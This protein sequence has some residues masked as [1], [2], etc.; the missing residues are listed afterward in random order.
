MAAWEAAL[1]TL[2]GLY[3]A[4]DLLFRWMG[5][6]ALAHGPRT[7]ARLALTFDDGPNP[8]TTPELLGILEDLKLHAT[9]FLTGRRA[10][11][12]PE[13][14]EAIR[15]AGHELASHGL[16]H[17]PAFLMAP[18]T[19][20]VHTGYDPGGLPLYRPPHGAHSPFTRLF[21]RMLGKQVALWDLESKDWT[22]MH[23]EALLERL[24]ELAQPGSVVL[25]HDG[26]PRTPGL[27]RR[28]VP[29]LQAMGYELVPLSAMELRPLSFK[30]GLIRA[31]Q[32]FDERYDRAHGIRRCRRSADNLFRC[33]PAPFPVDL[34]ELPK[35]TP[36]LELHFD[37]RRVAAKSPL[38]IVKA[39]RRDLTHAAERVKA[40][41]RIQVV[42]A[43]TPL[44]EGARELLGFELFDLP[45]GRALVDALSRRFFDWLYRDPRY[46]PKP[47]YAVKL[48]Y[49]KR[50][51]FLRK[52]GGP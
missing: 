6:G 15:K 7:K 21:A 38:A 29:E 32:G 33:A 46:P 48:I 19:E 37:S 44:V 36:G 50:E 28:L 35:G 20:W 22:R 45:K 10:R 34:P 4:S 26:I 24:L 5:V 13:L 1:A 3:G 39:L 9:F 43:T 42:F 2:L 18:W 16:F 49:L 25:L 23:D 14:V 31:L 12:H 17:R 27:V 30:E 8:E 11:Q 51:D 47:S 40:D 52:Y 41:P